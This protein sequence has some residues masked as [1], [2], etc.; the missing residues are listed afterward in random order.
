M[1]ENKRREYE[2]KE[3]A[4]WRSFYAA[5]KPHR[6]AFN[7]AMKQHDAAR[8]SALAALRAEYGVED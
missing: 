6:E 3:V 5:I 8:A 7:A 1:D 4:V 2:E